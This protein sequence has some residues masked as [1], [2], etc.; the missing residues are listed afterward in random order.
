MSYIK[1][2]KD[3]FA[4][5]VDDAYERRLSRSDRAVLS[6][7]RV[8][9][10]CICEQATELER[11]RVAIDQQEKCAIPIYDE[12]TE[13]YLNGTNKTNARTTQNVLPARDGS[14]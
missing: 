9:Y 3:V 12:E 7:I 13:S 10:S 14:G 11:A 6:A 5:K 1:L 4:G 8:L 2:I